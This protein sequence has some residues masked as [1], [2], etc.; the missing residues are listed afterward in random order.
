[1]YQ[2][3]TGLNPLHIAVISVSLVLSLVA[4][5]VYNFYQQY[6]LLTQIINSQMQEDKYICGGV[7]VPFSQELS[8]RASDL[9]LYLCKNGERINI[10]HPC[11]LYYQS[12]AS[13]L[14]GQEI[15]VEN[16]EG[17]II[18]VYSAD[19]VPGDLE[20][21]FTTCSDCSDIEE[22]E[23]TDSTELEQVIDKV[24]AKHMDILFERLYLD[25]NEDQPVSL[26]QVRELIGNYNCEA[27]CESYEENDQQADCD[28]NSDEENDFNEEND[29]EVD[30]DSD[31]ENDCSTKDNVNT[32]I[33]YDSETYFHKLQQEEVKDDHSS[34]SEDQYL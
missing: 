5:K 33:G 2:I 6:K 30:C 16:F 32:E 23:E 12:S 34:E 21:C 25:R 4:T 22:S 3:F 24:M 17:D 29:H 7:H 19:Q 20:D 27:D 11:G 18:H 26:D 1:M 14:G 9:T 10:T 13:Q 15:V 31:E 8:Q 28:S